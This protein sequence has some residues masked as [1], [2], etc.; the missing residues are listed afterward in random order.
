MAPPAGGSYV[1]WLTRRGNRRAVIWKVDGC[2]GDPSAAEQ[3][4][5]LCNHRR[6]QGDQSNEGPLTSIERRGSERICERADV[7]YDRLHAEYENNRQ[8]KEPVRR[9]AEHGNV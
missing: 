7:R 9:Q 2:S 1:L 3:T 6:R 8:R 4:T 5:S